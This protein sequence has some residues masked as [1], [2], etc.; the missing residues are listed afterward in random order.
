MLQGGGRQGVTTEGSRE[1][2]AGI[3]RDSQHRP[4]TLTSHSLGEPAQTAIRVTMGYENVA[5]A[6]QGHQ[7]GAFS[8]F[9]LQEIQS[10]RPFAVAGQYRGD[11]AALPADAT[12]QGCLPAEQGRSRQRQPEEEVRQALALQERILD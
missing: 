3:N 5:L 8:H 10:P 4:D 2:D 6:A 11:L 12:V 9:M 7:A 1:R